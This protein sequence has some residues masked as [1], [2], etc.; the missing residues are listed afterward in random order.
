M[1]LF[2]KTAQLQRGKDSIGGISRAL[3]YEK[4]PQGLST[5]K[6]LKR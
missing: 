4:R 1:G 5:G 6:T 3:R 2:E